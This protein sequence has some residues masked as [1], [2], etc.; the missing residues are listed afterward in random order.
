MLGCFG[1]SLVLPDQEVETT[2]SFVPPTS[3]F[4]KMNLAF[5]EQRNAN[6]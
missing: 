2:M 4:S 1:K 6:R 3:S 5:W